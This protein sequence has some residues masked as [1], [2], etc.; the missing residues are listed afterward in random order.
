M[1][2]EDIVVNMLVHGEVLREKINATTACQSTEA[3]PKQNAVR[4]LD[5]FH[6][7]L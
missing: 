3:S 7:E 1:I 2:L 6:C 4:M 5:S